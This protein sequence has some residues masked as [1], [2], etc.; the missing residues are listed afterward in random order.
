MS[1]GIWH[2][3]VMRHEYDYSDVQAN[4][5]GIKYYYA[6]H[7]FYPADNE[8]ER[9]KGSWTETACNP[10]GDTI[11]G[12]KDDLEY[13]LNCIEQYGIRDANT[14]ELIENNS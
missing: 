4:A 3:Q 5:L 8:N 7:E 11:N 10:Q 2:Y 12:L 13:M 9:K 1:D 14:G 6:V